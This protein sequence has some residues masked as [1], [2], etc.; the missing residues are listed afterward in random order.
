[1]MFPFTVWIRFMEVSV[2]FLCCIAC[3]RTYSNNDIL[4]SV[5]LCFISYLMENSF[6]NGKCSMGYLV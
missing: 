3:L 2:S 6:G 4:Q 5:Q 1:M